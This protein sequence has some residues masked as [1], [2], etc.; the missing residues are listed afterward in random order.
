MERGRAVHR[1]FE[2][3]TWYEDWSADVGRL[4]ALVRRVAP[5]RTEGWAREVV[6]YFL[7]SLEKPEVRAVMSRGDTPPDSVEIWRERRYA[8]LVAGGRGPDG[9]VQQGSIDRLEVTLDSGGRPRSARLIDFKTDQ[10][11]E[12]EATA[13]A[14][15]YRRQIDA[16]RSAAARMLLQAFEARKR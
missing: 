16:Y 4:V 15:T 3:V 12:R 10:V 13:S 8:Q 9:M 1:L 14:E 6:R 2:Q 5:R 7:G 11:S